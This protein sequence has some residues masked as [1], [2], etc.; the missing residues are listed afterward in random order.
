VLDQPAPEFVRL[1]RILGVF[2]K[3]SEWKSKK[4]KARQANRRRHTTK[5]IQ[6][7]SD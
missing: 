7:V 4:D 6:E 3:Y 1:E 2:E 5:K